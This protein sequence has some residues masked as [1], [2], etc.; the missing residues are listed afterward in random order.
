MS[1]SLSF[2]YFTAQGFVVQKLLMSAQDCPGHWCRNSVILRGNWPLQA[3]SEF[4]LGQSL[5]WV[6]VCAGVVGHHSLS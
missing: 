2:A 4:V 5:C 3:V 6:R 1:L